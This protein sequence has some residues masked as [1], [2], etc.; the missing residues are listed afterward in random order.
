MRPDELDPVAT[1]QLAALDRIVSG[2]P[3][4]EEHLELAALVESVRAGAPR[5]DEQAAARLHA[6][7]SEGR[8]PGDV[9]SGGLGTWRRS[10]RRLVS[11]RVALG[12]SAAALAAAVAAVVVI[13]GMGSSGGV[14]TGLGGAS[15]PAIART[16]APAVGAGSSSSAA[17]G[18]AGAGSSSS[19]AVGAASPAPATP[20]AALAQA[21]AGRLQQMAG[22]M[23]LA[24]GVSAVQ[25]VADRIVAATEQLGG[26]VESSNVTIQGAGSLASFV[27]RVPSASLGQEIAALS[28]LASVRALTQGT[29]DITDTYDQARAR[30]ATSRAERNALLAALARATTPNQTT[31]IR[32]QLDAIAGRIAADQRVVDG[33]LAEARN[34]ELQVTV[35]PAAAVAQHQHSST[36]LSRA[37]HDALRVLEVS[38]A[39]LVVA[40]AVLAPL[41]LLAVA[42]W[43]SAQA[44]RQRARERVLESM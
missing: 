11:G 32:D 22:S 21:P 29:Q 28:R 44:L 40:L 14:H 33:L 12:G 37:L 9:A 1:V 10:G 4:G 19:A 42:L 18:A 24:S 8:R 38:L 16:A 27:L 6:R 39:V 34:A 36:V 15:A 20:G 2:E 31:S 43:L 35:V 3:V 5:L 7:V 17:V 26:V 23:T 13:A 30:L 41:T 25:G